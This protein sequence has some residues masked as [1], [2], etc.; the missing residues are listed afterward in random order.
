MRE[1]NTWT[2]IIKPCDSHHSVFTSSFQDVGQGQLLFYCQPRTELITEETHVSTASVMKFSFYSVL[3][4]CFLLENHYAKENIFLIHQH[5]D[6]KTLRIFILSRCHW[7]FYKC[8]QKLF[9]PAQG[10]PFLGRFSVLRVLLTW[11]IL[12][13]SVFL[14]HH[15]DAAANASPS[16]ESEKGMDKRVSVCARW[17]ALGQSRSGAVL[18]KCFSHSSSLPGMSSPGLQ[19]Q[20]I[21]V[22]ARAQLPG[23]DTEVWGTLCFSPAFSQAEALCEHSHLPPRLRHR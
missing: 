23:Q 22:P 16:E 5:K 12:C 14:R 20:W 18:H 19:Q 6:D 9:L 2:W 1:F 11:E 3:F 15:D 17:G 8:D 21:A 10:N 4:S 7:N 13:R